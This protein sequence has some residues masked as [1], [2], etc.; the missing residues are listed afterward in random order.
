MSE[1]NLKKTD[2][3]MFITE[4]IFCKPKGIIID[5]A[6]WWQKANILRKHINMTIYFQIYDKDIKHW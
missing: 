4:K 3:A 2:V 6:E 5:K 1:F